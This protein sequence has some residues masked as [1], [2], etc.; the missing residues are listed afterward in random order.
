MLKT[1]NT[2]SENILHQLRP[3]SEKLSDVADR[4]VQVVGAQVL[5]SAFLTN[6]SSSKALSKPIS[7]RPP[8]PTN[9]VD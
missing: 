1:G 3:D 2:T 7:Q 5:G 4:S 9:P 6:P 8:K